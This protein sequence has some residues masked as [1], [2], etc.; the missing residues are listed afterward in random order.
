LDQLLTGLAR[1]ESLAAWMGLRERYRG[2]LAAILCSLEQYESRRKTGEHLPAPPDDLPP[3]SYGCWWVALVRYTATLTWQVDCQR[4]HPELVMITPETY[5]ARVWELAQKLREKRE[6]DPETI[7]RNWQS[8]QIPLKAQ[9]WK[10]WFALKGPKGGKAKRLREAV[11]AS[12]PHL[13]VM[14]PCWLV[15]PAT[16]SE[17]LPLQPGLFDLVVFDEAS[18]CPIEQAV[19]AVYRGN[20]LVVSGDE[21]QLPPTSF[22]QSAWS[23]EQQEPED[24][25]GAASAVPVPQNEARR[26]AT[27]DYLLQVEDLLAAAMGSLPEKWL[28]V[29][30]RS[31]HPA[32][33]EFSNRAFYNGRLEAPPARA[34]AFNGYRPIRYLEVNGRYERRTNLDEGRAVIKVLRQF[35]LTE[36]A[37]PT[38]GVVTFN[39]P[40]RDLL[41]DLIEEECRRDSRFEARFRQ[42]V[43]REQ[44]N[45]DVGFFVRNLEN[46]Q[47]DERDV[48]VF[49]TTFGREPNGQFYRR[50]GPVG[51]V[52]GE[53]RLNVAVTRAK[54]Q[55]VVVGS[56][57]IDSIST[58]LSVGFAPGSQLTPSC[59]LQLYLAYA[60]AVSD[61]DQERIQRVL[62]RLG[63]EF[64]PLTT[65]EV[66]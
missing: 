2:P 7:R 15:N 1:L 61:N 66:E 27:V 41:E 10:K 11:E 43:S 28:G 40:Q 50:F 25:T 6:L 26:K 56:M 22:F 51:A 58:A 55:V 4:R 46:V 59:Y 53:R 35:W 12:L 37:C 63:H 45:Q 48:I 65:G 21:K 32:L 31:E 30:Y 17:V 62:G 19:P 18:Q 20:T 39:Q 44:D 29:H 9:P 57:P 64:A 54:Q 36:G 38:L 13:L 3:D 52:G 23:E 14:R 47:G 49:S 16:V 24:D 60:K 42:E 8:R 33:I 5:A 34:A